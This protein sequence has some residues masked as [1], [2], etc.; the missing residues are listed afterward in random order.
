M[1]L[2]WPWWG[3]MFV[4][5]L[6]V[7]CLGAWSTGAGRVFMKTLAV[8]L[9]LATTRLLWPDL[10]PIKNTPLYLFI[11]LLILAVGALIGDYVLGL[12]LGRHDRSGYREDSVGH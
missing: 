7:G 3:K 9:L 5:G 1:E 10:Y 12:K 8:P 2:I 4:L 11:D 6:G